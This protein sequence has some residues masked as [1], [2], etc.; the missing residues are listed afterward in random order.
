MKSKA[1]DDFIN[2]PKH[3]ETNAKNYVD[4]HDLKNPYISPLYA[5]L[6]GFPPL[7]IQVGTREVMLNDST[8]LAELARKANLDV[9]LDVWEGMVHVFQLGAVFVPEAR[10][11][12]ENIAAFLQRNDY[13]DFG[14]NTT[15]RTS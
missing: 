7:F 15:R 13:R 8:R 6:T 9:T 4:N 2:Y 10:K 3:M 1:R 12:V 14:N 5:D 11:A